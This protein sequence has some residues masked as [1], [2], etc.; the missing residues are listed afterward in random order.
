[1]QSL[2]PRRFGVGDKITNGSRNRLVGLVGNPQSPVAG[3]HIIN[4]NKDF[5]RSIYALYQNAIGNII[6][7]PQF[8]GSNIY[9]AGKI[10]EFGVFLN[11]FN[12][13]LTNQAIFATA[14]YGCLFWRPVSDTYRAER[15]YTSPV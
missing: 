12:N 5:K 14:V 9:S 3:L 15:D 10:I 6:I 4:N 2:I 8:F 1:M 7:G 13:R 11:I